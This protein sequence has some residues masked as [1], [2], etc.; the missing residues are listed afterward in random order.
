MGAK[1]FVKTVI[2]LIPYA[3][4]GGVE[5]AAQTM[6]N[7]HSS[8]LN[9]QVR[10]LF[11]NVHSRAQRLATF[12]PIQF[13]KVAYE[14][15]I[16]SPDVLI[17]S[18]W[19]SALVGIL[20]RIMCPRICLI[21]FIHNS[22]DAHGFDYLITRIAIYLSDEVWSDSEA[23]LAQRFRGPINKRTRRI[24]FLAHHV[25]PDYQYKKLQPTFIFWGRMSAQ[26]DLPRSLRLFASVRKFA[27]KANYLIIGPDGDD[28][29]H[30]RAVIEELNISKSLQFI[31]P[32][33]FGGIQNLISNYCFYLQTS[34]YEGMAMSVVEAMQFGLVPVVTPVGEIANYTQHGDNAI[35]VRDDALAVSEIVD[36]LGDDSRFQIMRKKAISTW[37]GQPLYKDSVIEACNAL[38]NSKDM[39]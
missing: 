25:E 24:S 31:G 13:L 38:F 21:V 7:L 34:R 29:A 16:E 9:F 17:V 10:Y 32:M 27:P 8:T 36:L 22:A 2:H 39:K 11:P 4:I 30:I 19:R 23:S 5:A 28:T 12:N 26:K 3:G 14:I 20:A 15:S 33:E 6:S 35:Q 1:C 37:S 18:L